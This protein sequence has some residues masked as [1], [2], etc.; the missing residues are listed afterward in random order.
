MAGAGDNPVRAE[1]RGGQLLGGQRATVELATGGGDTSGGSRKAQPRPPTFAEA[2][3]ET[4]F[5]E[6]E[7]CFLAPAATAARNAF[8]ACRLFLLF[9]VLHFFAPLGVPY[10]VVAGTAFRHH[11]ADFH[12]DFLLIACSRGIG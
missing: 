10:V 1:R 9:F 7:A 11:G 3:L 12:G 8:R 2:V 5:E 6:H 4:D